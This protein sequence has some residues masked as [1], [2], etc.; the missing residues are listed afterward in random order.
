VERQWRRDEIR[1]MG[2]GEIALRLGNT[3]TWTSQLVNRR[4]FPAPIARLKVGQIWLAD[5]VEDWIR[6]N[7]PHLNEPDEA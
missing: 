3:P 4:E 1:L 5:D 2:I 7:R 6:E